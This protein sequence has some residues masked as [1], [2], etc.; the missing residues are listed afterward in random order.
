MPYRGDS[1][2]CLAA[3]MNEHINKPVRVPELQAA[4]ERSKPAV[5]NQELL[6]AGPCMPPRP[7]PLVLD[8]I[9]ASSHIPMLVKKKRH[10]KGRRF[11]GFWRR[12]FGHG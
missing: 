1:E 10:D 12:G 11:H 9:P 4:L 8:T 2:K 3:G 7:M 5:K 6:I